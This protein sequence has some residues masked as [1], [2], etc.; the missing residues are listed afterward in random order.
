MNHL[1]Q[2]ISFIRTSEEIEID[3]SDRE[4]IIKMIRPTIG[5]KTIPCEDKD[6]KVGQSKF[7]GKPDL[8]KDFTWPRANGKPMLFCAQY[9]LSELTDLDKEDIL[10]KKGFFHIFLALDEKGTGFSGMDH[11]FKFS[12][13]EDENLVRTEFPND[14]EDHHSFQPALIQYVEFYTIPD[15]EN[16]KYFELQEKYDDDLYDLFYQPLKNS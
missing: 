10:P 1:D 8:P 3:P 16:Y 13:S 14:L 4:E 7:G 6:I 2:L 12:F 15:A 11:S 9:N 5:M